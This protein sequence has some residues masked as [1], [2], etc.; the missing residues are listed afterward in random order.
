MS[1]LPIH[2]S[3]REVGEEKVGNVIKKIFRLQI[4]FVASRKTGLLPQRE[5]TFLSL[6]TKHFL[7]LP[8]GLIGS[9]ELNQVNT[10]EF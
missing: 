8:H 6:F 3:D 1:N 4:W 9:I 2:M 5:M 7:G 10:L